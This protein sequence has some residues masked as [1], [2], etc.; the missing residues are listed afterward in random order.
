MTQFH[1]VGLDLSLTKTG[2]AIIRPGDAEPIRVGLIE[3]ASIP[4]DAPDKYPLTLARVRRLASKIVQ[5]VHDMT[6]RGADDVVVIVIEGPALGQNMG[7]AHIRA[8]LWWLV[9]HLVEKIG[10]VVVIEP[11]KLKRYV[12][13]KGSGQKDLVFSTIVRNFPQVDVVDNNEADALGLACMAA[14][15]LGFPQEPS[16]QRCDPGALEGVHWPQFI[17]ARRTAG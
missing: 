3:S 5:T 11:T 9:Y 10:H 7:Q 13:R 1:I 4:N 8:G 12:T 16:V 14:R 15:E 17:T 2:W 6:V